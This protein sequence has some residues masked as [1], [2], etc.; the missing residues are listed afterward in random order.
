MSSNQEIIPFD[1]KNE[2]KSADKPKDN[3]NQH[4]NS[5]SNK[6]ISSTQQDYEKNNETKNNNNQNNNC[7]DSPDNKQISIELHSDI[8]RALY[9][10]EFVPLEKEFPALTFS[11]CFDPSPYFK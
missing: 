5:L 9:P 3:S 11:A 4:I 2:N 8:Q 7:K 1:D 6:K 10:S